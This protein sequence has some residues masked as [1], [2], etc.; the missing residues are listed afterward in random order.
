MAEWTV[1]AVNGEEP[2]SA[3]EKEQAVVEAATADNPNVEIENTDGVI[4]V[5]LDNPPVKEEQK[6]EADAVQQ[7]QG[8][9]EE[10]VLRDERV[11]DEEP[12]QETEGSSE[13]P[14]PDT[15]ETPEEAPVIELVSQQ[16]EETVTEEEIQEVLQDEVHIPE[17]LESL[18]KFMDETGGSLE[19]YVSLNKSYDELHPVDL[20]K[21][22]YQKKYPHYNDERLDRRMSKDFG[23]S[24][25]DDPDAI[26]DKK[27][28]FEDATYE[29][30][31]FLNESKDKY[32][33]ELKFNR[34]SNLAP[35]VKEATEF[36]NDYKKSQEDNK[37]V[38]AKF[39]DQTSKLFNEEF[40]GFDFKV[41]DNK[42]RFKVSDVAKTKEYQS[43][44]NN[45]IGEFAN[46]EGEI[47]D[48]AGYHK[49]IFAAK[50]ADKIA[51]HFYEQGRADAIT[52]SAKTSKNIDMTPRSDASAVVQTKTGNQYKVV[53]GDSSSSLRFKIKK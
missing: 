10:G 38:H 30:K 27:D 50:N 20:V 32:Y 47:S 2:K 4:K 24:E 6:E 48:V 26:Q 28:A 13:Q 9:T 52:N 44:L 53:S 40:K 34:Q 14:E 16:E 3:Q 39:A 7:V 31:R 12:S 35:E 5:D 25:D 51:Q 42:Y 22:Y 37:Q 8:E 23:F 29:A 49:A 11:A 19:D 1:K 46:E 21:E 17:G 33:N 41:G 15:Q 18:V 45:F 43:D 36:Y